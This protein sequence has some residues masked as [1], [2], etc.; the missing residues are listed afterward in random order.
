MASGVQSMGTDNAADTAGQTAARSGSEPDVHPPD[1]CRQPMTPKNVKN[2]TL[3]IVTPSSQ[4]IRAECGGPVLSD[5]TD[6]CNGR[7]QRA[8]MLANSNFAFRRRVS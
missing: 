2:A 3:S 5:R 4:V 1:P 8:L 7:V 6:R